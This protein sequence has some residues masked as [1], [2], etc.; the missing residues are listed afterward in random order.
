MHKN[1]PFLGLIPGVGD[2]QGSLVYCGP[3][4]HKESDTTEWLNWTER[5]EN[6]V[7]EEANMQAEAQQKKDKA[8]AQVNLCAPVEV[9]EAE[10]RDCMPAL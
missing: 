9:R 3:W 6:Q 4:G 7:E 5:H 8:E 2:G 10:T 1:Q